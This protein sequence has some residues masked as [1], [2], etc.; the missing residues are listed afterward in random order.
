MSG[1]TLLSRTV[2]ITNNNV[3]AWWLAVVGAVGLVL[4]GASGLPLGRRK[5]V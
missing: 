2:A 1:D 4:G 3:P 5:K